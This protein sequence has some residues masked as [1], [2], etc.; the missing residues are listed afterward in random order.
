M[1]KYHI[2]KNITYGYFDFFG[3]SI[4]RVF[5]GQ[6]SRNAAKSR[7]RILWLLKKFEKNQKT[8][9]TVGIAQVNCDFLKTNVTAIFLQS[10]RNLIFL[11]KIPI[12]GLSQIK[13]K[14]SGEKLLWKR[15]S[16]M[17]T[18]VIKKQKM[19]EYSAAKIP[20]RWSVFSWIDMSRN[21]NSWDAQ[22]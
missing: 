10:R 7:F 11:E 21:S 20:Y 2:K 4:N 19:I 14:I 9:D 3:C 15:F 17:P 12:L 22:M 8:E 18:I 1:K 13:M 5:L 16:I 6:K